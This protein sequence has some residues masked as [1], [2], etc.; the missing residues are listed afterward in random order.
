MKLNF[1]QDGYPEIPHIHLATPGRKLLTT[2]NG[3]RPDSVSLNMRLNNTWELSFTTDRYISVHD[4]L[5]ESNGYHLLDDKMK[6]YV[7]QIGWF[8]LKTPSVSNDGNTEAKQITAESAEIEW[9]DK[10]LKG[11][12][13]NCGTTDSMEMLV[14][15]NV[16]FIDGVEFPLHQIVFCD[17]EHPELSLLHIAMKAARLTGWEVGYVDEIPHIYTSYLDGEPV[18]KVIQLKDEIGTF[19]IDSSGLYSFFTQDLSRFFQCIFLF[20]IQN[21]RINVYRAEH[22]G[23]DTSATISFR[24]FQSSNEITCSNADDICTCC[25]VSGGDNLGI[26]QVN[27]GWNYIEDKSYFLN[28]RYLSSDLIAKYN[29]WKAYTESRRYEYIGLTRS[30]LSLI[31]I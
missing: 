7:D 6:L 31:H 16:E 29:E 23:K 18:E 8:I 1:D 11:F 20:D 15:G 4:T 3:I 25:Y 24:N 17:K 27:F 10:T 12:K 28:T 22:L 14:P 19:D 26:E 9:V 2:L 13:I 30:Y 5:V 21:Y